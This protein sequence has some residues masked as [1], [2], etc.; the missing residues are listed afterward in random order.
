LQ[1]ALRGVGLPCDGSSWCAADLS[2]GAW[3][4]HQAARRILDQLGAP[5]DAES[6]GNVATIK[7]LELAERTMRA[8]ERSSARVVLVLAPRFGQVW[9]PYD[10]AYLRFLAFGL[11]G[12][13]AKLVLV[14]CGDAALADPNGLVVD[15]WNA[16][17]PPRPAE[18]IDELLALI[19]DTPTASSTCRTTAC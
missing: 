10:L 11:A 2:L 5:V 1:A 15:W 7:A 19:P 17:Q 12:A 4:V 18:Q 6:Q 3:T 9:R 13:E 14:S 16:P 8:L